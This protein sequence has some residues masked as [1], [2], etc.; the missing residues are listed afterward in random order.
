M[1][2][3]ATQSQREPPGMQFLTDLAWRFSSVSPGVGPDF[4][5]SFLLNSL[6]ASAF[7]SWSEIT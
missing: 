1:R 2:V 4:I 7:V 6:E 3:A 5:V